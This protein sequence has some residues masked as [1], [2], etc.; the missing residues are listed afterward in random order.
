MDKETE[1]GALERLLDQAIVKLKIRLN[2]LENA[3][4]ILQEF[5]LQVIKENPSG[6]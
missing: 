5:Q 6:N 4:A 1:E 2:Q 3:K